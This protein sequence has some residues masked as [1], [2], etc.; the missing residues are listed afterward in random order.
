MNVNEQTNKHDDS[1][2][3]K[4]GFFSAEEVSHMTAAD[5][6]DHYEDIMESMKKW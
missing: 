3:E 5:V 4:G 2:K 6:R 1:E